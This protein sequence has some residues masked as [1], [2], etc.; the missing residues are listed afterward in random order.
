MSTQEK[1]K[2]TSIFSPLTMKELK[3]D[4]PKKRA[5]ID[6]ITTWIRTLVYNWRQGTVKVK[7]RSD[8]ARSGRK[9]WKQKGT[10]KARAGTARSPLWRG[11]GVIFG[12]QPKTKTLRVNKQTR[13]KV[14]I[15]VLTDYLKDKNVLLV[16]WKLK[17]EKPSSAQATK[18]LKEIGI[19][20]QKVILLLPS[21]DALTYASFLNIPN[22]RIL[23]FDQ[24]NIY[25]LLAG[26]KWLV[27]KK[28]LETFKE[29]VAKWQ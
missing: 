24:P 1:N 7:G 14:L 18:L 16:D 25:H 26:K 21:N 23:F 4:V 8:V 20:K 5:S 15:T 6:Q 27:L 13:K 11:G 17:G 29:M 3:V 2:Q 22:V 28:D 9:P 12:P 19:V 10:G